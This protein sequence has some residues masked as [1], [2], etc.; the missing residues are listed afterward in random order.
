VK[1]RAELLI[2]VSNEPL[3]KHGNRPYMRWGLLKETLAAAIILESG[4]LSRAKRTGKMY[5]WDPF[6]GSGSFLIESIMMMLE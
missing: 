1:D 6:C 5:L 3:S 2:G 4:I